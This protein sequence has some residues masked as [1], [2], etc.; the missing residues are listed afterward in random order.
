MFLLWSQQDGFCIERRFPI[1]II[2]FL[3]HSSDADC[4]FDAD[5]EPFRPY[6]CVG[7]CVLYYGSA[8]ELGVIKDLSNENLG[9]RF[10]SLLAVGNSRP[11]HS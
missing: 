1:L 10:P 6:C 9:S 11:N 2:G 5:V 4:V 7:F 8:A 3:V